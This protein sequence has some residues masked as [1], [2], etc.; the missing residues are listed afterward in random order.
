LSLSQR[1]IEVHRAHVMEKMQA[2][3][4]A[5]LVQKMSRLEN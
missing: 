5:L 3:S 1:T 2:P 4:L